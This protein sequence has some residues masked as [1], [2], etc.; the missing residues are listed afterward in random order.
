VLIV[1]LIFFYRTLIAVSTHISLVTFFNLFVLH[2]QHRR[3][4]AVER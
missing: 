2:L 3:P 4:I 1:Q